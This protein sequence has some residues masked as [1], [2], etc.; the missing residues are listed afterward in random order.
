MRKMDSRAST[1]DTLETREQSKNKLLYHLST[2]E[3]KHGCSSSV[4][5]SLRL[6]SGVSALFN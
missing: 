2:V 5:S 3:D 1:A 4:V 6:W